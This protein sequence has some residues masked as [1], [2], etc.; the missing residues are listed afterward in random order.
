MTTTAVELRAWPRR[1]WW[2]TILLLL[3]VQV[4]LVFWLG[5]RS[6]P[7]P[8]QASTNPA[9]FLATELPN[10]LL[11]LNNPT[12]LA[13]A[14]RRGFSGAAWLKIPPVNYQLTD[15][16]EPPRWL[17][18]PADDLGNSFHRFAQSNLPY[19][20]PIADKLLPR[21]TPPEFPTPTTSLPTRSSLRVEGELAA[22][23]LL[24]QFNLPSW[25]N[26][27]LLTNSIVQ[28]LV[29]AEGRTI[30]ATLLSGSGSKE[31]DQCALK[32]AK[33]ARFN[34]LRVSGP[35]RL[36]ETVPSLSWGQLIFD[37][38]TVPMPATNAP[39]ANP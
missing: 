27:D 23:H 18:L 35:D 25:T 31:A 21:F 4:G 17:P 39:P 7:I 38:H 11:A 24:A 9:V 15:W 22:R 20:F 34:S 30:S 10:E 14:N 33:T 26:S 19:P 29:D 6:L 12:L 1:R 8:R 5:D 16:T 28:I 2:G 13:W 32:V 37:W 36:A 3:G